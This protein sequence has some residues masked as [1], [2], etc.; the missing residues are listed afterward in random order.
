MNTQKVI[1]ILAFT[2]VAGAHAATPTTQSDQPTDTPVAAAAPQF[3]A[4]TFEQHTK[5]MQGIHEKMMAARSPEERA[6]LRHEGMTSMQNGM[7][8]M[9]QM[10]KDMGAGMHMGNHMGGNG[11]PMDCTG[12]DRRMEMMD[13]MMQLMIDQ[14]VPAKQ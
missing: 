6:A 10:R 7:A 1:A 4:A 14:Q 2:F 3:D 11:M 12:E 8:M 13:A 5:A 9:G